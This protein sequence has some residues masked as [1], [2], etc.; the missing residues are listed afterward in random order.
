MEIGNLSNKELKVM[1]IKTIKELKRRTDE[2]SEQLEV[3]NK[4]KI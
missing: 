2:H 1:I 4:E 3:F